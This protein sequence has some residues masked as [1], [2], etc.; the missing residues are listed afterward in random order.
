MRD[1]SALQASWR[2]GDFDTRKLDVVIASLAKML[3]DNRLTEKERAMLSDDLGR[4]RVFKD[5]QSWHQ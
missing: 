2:S 4:L 5:N 3:G 1:L